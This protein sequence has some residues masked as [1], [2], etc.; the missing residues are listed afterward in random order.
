VAALLIL[1]I[2]SIVPA[3]AAGSLMLKGK[4][5][6]TRGQSALAGGELEVAADSFEEA[7]AAFHK[8]GNQPGALLL[9]GAGLIP[10]LG[11][12]PKTIVGLARAGEHVSTAGLAVTEG[13]AEL[14]GGLDGLAPRDGHLPIDQMVLIGPSLGQARDEI[15]A[16]QAIADGLPRSMVL[17]RVGEA[18]QL[19]ERKLDDA[20]TLIRSAEELAR[21]LPRFAGS[22]EPRTYFVAAQNPAELRGTGGLI[23]EWA[24]L[25]FRDGTMT[26]SPFRSI[27]EIRY[28]GQGEP[29]PKPIDLPDPDQRFEPG[30]AIPQPEGVPSIY[31]PDPS[32]FPSDSNVV[33]Q[34]PIAAR[35]LLDQYERAFGERL[36]GVIYADPQALAEL[37]KATGPIT[38]RDLGVTLTP[39]SVVPYTTNEA[40]F[41]FDD[42]GERKDALG[43][44]AHEILQAFLDRASAERALSAVVTAAAQGHLKLYAED[45]EVQRAFEATGI[46]GDL[47]PIAAPS[48][49]LAIVANNWAGN[50]VDFY[51]TPKITYD[52]K[53]QDQGAAIA[54]VSVLYTNDAPR[55]AKPSYALGPYEGADHENHN[56]G[57]G[58]DLLQTSTYC[59]WSCQLIDSTLDGKP[60][61]MLQNPSGDLTLFGKWIHI[62]AGESKDIGL[63]LALGQAWQSSGTG[64]IYRLRLQGQPTIRPTTATV[65][66]HAPE[67]ATF[68]GANR[69]DVSIQGAVATWEG[70]IGRATDLELEFERP[71]VDRLWDFLN[72]PAIKF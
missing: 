51:L 20:A 4:D 42:T 35:F 9:K 64:G 40:Y 62:R 5:A 36:D 57:V 22:E 11:N 12:T 41:D 50:K 7:Q 49:Y 38:S 43:V 61:G 2:L 33:P 23:S 66:I 71:F 21:V 37:L 25:T 18:S 68:V 15:D 10:F 72:K 52:V 46:A 27:K 28:P 56:L 59:A 29:A 19:V 8:A 3:L 54:D 32:I 53:L 31:G 47:R 67:G 16:A 45:P 69:E 17:G 14:P 24:T 30:D 58:E 63:E 65:T 39:E 6:L 70:P 26:L 44:A 55:G 48:D 1:G 34:V 13:V 60:S